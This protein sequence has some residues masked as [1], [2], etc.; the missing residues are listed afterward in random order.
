MGPPECFQWH[1]SAQFLPRVARESFQDSGEAER[2]ARYSLVMSRT[3][4]SKVLVL[5]YCG[6]GGVVEAGIV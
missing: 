3:E 4:D 1:F 5:V 2:R 6:D